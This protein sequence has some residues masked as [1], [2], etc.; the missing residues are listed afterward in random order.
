MFAENF[1]VQ[2]IIV[3]MKGIFFVSRRWLFSYIKFSRI[4]R[5]VL[6]FFEECVDIYDIREDVTVETEK[7]KNCP[8][9]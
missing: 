3:K 5:D 9:S 2:L 1:T 6:T 7:W 4:F 8:I